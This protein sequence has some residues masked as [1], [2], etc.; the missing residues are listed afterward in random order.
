MG[1]DLCPELH[2]RPPL[3]SAAKSPKRDGVGGGDRRGQASRDLQGMD[4][5]DQWVR[6]RSFPTASVSLAQTRRGI[7]QASHA[8]ASDAL[9]LRRCFFVL[10]PPEPYPPLAGISV[11]HTCRGGTSFWCEKEVWWCVHCN[12]NQSVIA[13]WEPSEGFPGIA[14]P[15]P[16]PWESS[17][18]NPT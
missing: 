2:F 18:S 14:C 17:C 10:Q 16:A 8:T 12:N 7:S 5:P 3:N 6:S 1:P 9:P 11:G 13:S 4:K 15:L